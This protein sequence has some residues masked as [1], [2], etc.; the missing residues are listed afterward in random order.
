[1]SVTRSLVTRSRRSTAVNE[2]AVGTGTAMAEQCHAI[3]LQSRMCSAGAEVAC[4]KSSLVPKL[5]VEGS[6]WWRRTLAS[7]GNG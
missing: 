4:M 5:R 2:D 6:R 7:L 3:T 1:M